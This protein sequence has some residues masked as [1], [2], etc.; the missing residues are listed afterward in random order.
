MYEVRLCFFVHGTYTVKRE[1]V[2]FSQ[3]IISIEFIDE[4]YDDFN[5]VTT[6]SK[7]P[8]ELKDHS[9]YLFDFFLPF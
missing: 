7:S 6:F 8:H 2:F 9:L 4:M 1:N 3:E 5:S